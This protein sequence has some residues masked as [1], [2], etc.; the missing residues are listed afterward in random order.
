MYCMP[1]A[2]H[3]VE[4]YRYICSGQTRARQFEAPNMKELRLSSP[5]SL[6]V[7]TSITDQHNQVEHA[8]A[9]S[10]RSRS[11]C[12]QVGSIYFLASFSSFLHPFEY[13]IKTVDGTADRRE[14]MQQE[15]DRPCSP[16]SVNLMISPCPL[17]WCPAWLTDRH[18]DR[19]TA[20]RKPPEIRLHPLCASNVESVFTLVRSFESRGC[21]RRHCSN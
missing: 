21:H 17:L 1:F 10:P 7:A 12:T 4:S 9:H 19:P 6:H 18:V 11:Q 5:A 2:H 16:Q 20:E 3:S 15:H 14:S 8:I 13:P